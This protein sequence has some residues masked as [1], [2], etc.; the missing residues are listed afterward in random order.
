MDY[1]RIN[2]LLR[3]FEASAL[4]S[5]H[6]EEGDFKLSVSKLDT[7]LPHASEIKTVIT[8]PDL[9]LQ[10]PAIK[11]QIPVDPDEIYLRHVK[12]P[13]V[14]TYYDGDSPEGNPFVQLGQSVKKGDT[15]C[16]IEA[17]KIMNEI[18]APCSGVVEKKLVKNGSVVGFDQ[19]MIV[20]RTKE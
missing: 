8:N 7:P 6:I 1:K 5:L 4:T 18:A 10:N 15:V 20:I 11:D 3:Y 19:S 12:S 9:A 17:M 16:I 2:E 14:G 13:L